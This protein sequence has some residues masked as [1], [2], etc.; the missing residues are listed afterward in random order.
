M[1][2]SSLIVM[3]PITMAAGTK[4]MVKHNVVV[5]NFKLR[6]A[7]GA[8]TDTSSD[9]A[10]TLTQGET[11]VKRAWIPAPGTYTASRFDWNRLKL[12]FDAD[13]KRKVA[14]KRITNAYKDYYGPRGEQ[15]IEMTDQFHEEILRNMESLI[16]MNLRALALASKEF[17]Q[18]V[19]CWWYCVESLDVEQ[20]ISQSI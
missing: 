12:L 9:K 6:E 2:P 19:F 3:F 20:R 5:C 15:P 7:L 13:V 10:G 11:V 16:M 4:Y 8:F 18:M 1:I 17:T 14:V